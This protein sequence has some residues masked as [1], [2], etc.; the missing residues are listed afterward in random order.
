M[1]LQRG[2]SHPSYV[3]IFSHCYLLMVARDRAIYGRLAGKYSKNK[4]YKVSA[5]IHAK[6]PVP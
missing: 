4:Y 6:K 3:K 5:L 2:G 1:S